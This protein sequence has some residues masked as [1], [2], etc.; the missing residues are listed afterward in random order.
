MKTEVITGFLKNNFMPDI[1]DY[2]LPSDF[3]MELPKEVITEKKHHVIDYSAMENKIIIGL[4]GYAKSGKDFITKTFIEDYGYQRVAFA[5]NI[6]KE[7]NKYLKEAVCENLNK[8]EQEQISKIKNTLITCEPWTVDRIDFFTEDLQT[9]KAL[10]PYI[11]WYGEKL[12]NINGRFCWINRAFTEDAKNVD[13]VVLSD[14]RRLAEL[15]IFKNS[16]E[17]KKRI[18]KI[19]A[20]AGIYNSDASVNNFSTL[21]FEVSQ[22]GLTDAD[23]L[24]T[25][26][27]Q[28]A[29]EQWLIDETFYVYPLLPEEGAHRTKAMV[30]QIKRVVKEFGIEK[31]EKGKYPQMTIF[32]KENDNSIHFSD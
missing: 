19:S 17:Y 24:T 32:S 26:T 10:R 30:A 25:E 13:K 4:M 20:D 6:K 8:R 9:K 7:M 21:L 27:I 18:G 23:V 22:L 31:P 28:A 3:D 29:H 11:I 2:K 12:R 16:N 1:F 5:D 15:D 14:V